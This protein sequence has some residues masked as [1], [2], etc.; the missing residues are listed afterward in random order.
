MPPYPES[1]VRVNAGQYTFVRVPPIGNATSL[2]TFVFVRGEAIEV[3]SIVELN[4]QS[5][6]FLVFRPYRV[7]FREKL[8]KFHPNL[9]P[10]LYWNPTEPLAEEVEQWGYE[11]AKT[12]CRLELRR[13]VWQLLKKGICPEAA[14]VY[15]ACV[16]QTDREQKA[17]L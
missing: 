9:T 16:S 5:F 12:I 10:D 15:Q 8:R 6:E 3:P 14:M 4:D 2:E 7:A 11:L 13:R 17:K 1:R